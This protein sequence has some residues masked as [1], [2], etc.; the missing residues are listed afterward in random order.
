MKARK[1]DASQIIPFQPTQFIRECDLSTTRAPARYWSGSGNPVPLPASERARMSNSTPITRW[2][3]VPYV[4]VGPI[5]FGQTRSQVRSLLGG[6]V[7]VFRKG[8]SASTE[9]D[10]F[11]EL[12]LHLHYDAQDRLE[13]IEAWGPCPIYYK[14][15]ALLNVGV[16]EVLARLAGLGLLSRP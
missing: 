12:G 9:T 15:V 8:P 4:G 7:S 13:C 11:N 1:E 3:I 14:D 2:E 10:A 16:Q 6:N 5:Q